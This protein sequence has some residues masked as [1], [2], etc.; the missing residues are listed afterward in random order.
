MK[1]SLPLVILSVPP[2]LLGGVKNL[3]ELE[4]SLPLKKIAPSLSFPPLIIVFLPDIIFRL[5]STPVAL[6]IILLDFVYVVGRRSVSRVPEFILL[7]FRSSLVREIVP[8]L[9]GNA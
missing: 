8:F 5:V 9:S 1:E 4:P 3:Y 7:A 6:T 2:G